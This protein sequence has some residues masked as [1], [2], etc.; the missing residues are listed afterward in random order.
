MPFDYSAIGT[1]RHFLSHPVPPQSHAHPVLAIVPPGSSTSA[2]TRVLRLRNS[3]DTELPAHSCGLITPVLPTR[4][5]NFCLLRPPSE[6]P[7]TKA[8]NSCER[9]L[10][11][12]NMTGRVSLYKYP[13]LGFDEA[14]RLTLFCLRLAYI[15]V[16]KRSYWKSTSPACSS[17]V[18]T[19]DWV[20]VVLRRAVLTTGYCVW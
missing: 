13:L 17:Y 11:S 1:P 12:A 16:T 7:T 5:N 18:F 20:L 14:L 2:T 19:A 9:V 6:Q 15:L 4:R 8:E 3:C 10:C